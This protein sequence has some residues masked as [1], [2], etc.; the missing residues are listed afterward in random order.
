[1]RLLTTLS[2]LIATIF[3]HGCGTINEE[4]PSYEETS[5]VNVGDEAPDFTATTLAGDMFTLSEHRGEVVLLILFSHTCPD[6]KA[7]LDDMNG[8]LT[9]I[10]ALGA[11]VIAI[12]REGNRAD[13]EEYMIK[14]G[15]LFDV[16]VDNNREIYNSYATMYVPRT[17]LINTEGIV[18]YTTIEYDSSYIPTILTEINYLLR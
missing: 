1:M 9:D 8:V 4:L 2:I 7:L 6:C 5:I 3:L 14:N 15:Y 10:E 12:A 11:R 16:V 17:Y 13:I 18:T